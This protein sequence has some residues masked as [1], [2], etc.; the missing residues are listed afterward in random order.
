MS[1]K[2]DMEVSVQ[3][4]IYSMFTIHLAF[5]FCVYDIYQWVFIINAGA[6]ILFLA[7]YFLL[8]QTEFKKKIKLQ[9]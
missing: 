2:Y 8:F 6:C 1:Q 7:R 5:I 9:R 3:K 4:A